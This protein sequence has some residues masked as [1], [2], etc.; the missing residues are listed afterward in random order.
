[1]YIYEKRGNESINLFVFLDFSEDYGRAKQ[2]SLYSHTRLDIRTS[3][4]AD[5]LCQRMSVCEPPIRGLCKLLGIH[6][7]RQ[8]VVINSWAIAA[9][10]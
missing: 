6:F 5:H 3:F 7:G 4:D 8:C 10:T 1:M 9:Y 2:S